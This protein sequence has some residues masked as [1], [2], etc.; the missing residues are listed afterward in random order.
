MKVWQSSSFGKDWGSCE[1]GDYLQT[2]V[3]GGTLPLVEAFENGRTT[4]EA[5]TRVRIKLDVMEV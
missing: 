4:R 3:V 2:E 5:I 1:D